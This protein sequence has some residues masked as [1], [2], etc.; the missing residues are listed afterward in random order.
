[1]SQTDN[2]R[3]TCKSIQGAFL[4]RY[5]NFLLLKLPLMYLLQVL[6]LTMHFI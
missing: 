1:M 5:L 2:Q 4:G 6:Y 3:A